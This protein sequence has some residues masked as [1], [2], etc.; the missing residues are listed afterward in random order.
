VSQK[1]RLAIVALLYFVEGFPYGI[2]RSVWPVY[3]RTHGASLESVG[4]ISGLYF[5]WSLKFLWSPIVG[6]WGNAQRWIA[7]AL[8]I[9]A[10]ALLALGTEDAATISVLAWAILMVFCAASATQ[11]IAID[12]YTIGLVPRG[13]EGP[14]NSVRITAYRIGLVSA[15][16]PLLVLAGRIGWSA[17]FFIA[18]LLLLLLAGTVSRTPRVGPPRSERSVDPRPAFRTWLARPGALGVLGFVLL[19]RLA[20]LAMVPML[21]P[22]WVDRG[23]TL[24]RIALVSNTLGPIATVAGAV[25]GGVFV[26]RKGIGAS[27]FVLGAIALLPNLG[28]ATVAAL[29]ELGNP[30]VY[31]AS[32]LESFCAGLAS[33]A[34]LACLMRI[35][36]RE[37]AAVQYACLSALY[38]LP[39]TLAGVVSGWA[40]HHVGYASYFAATALLGLPAYAFLPW[41]RPW[42]QDDPSPPSHAKGER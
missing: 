6:A 23:I 17:A 15:G 19:Y 37:Y 3:Y 21:Q 30:G 4:L 14:A 32:V 27:L 41:V 33:A 25:S 42:V 36:E 7:G 29:P 12:A 35:C 1:R 24:S 28:Y 16:G 38:A 22:F 2:F 20:D 13:E 39:G 9:M 10:A 8:C 31:A 11:D 34:F 26:A 18:A 40:A 5:A